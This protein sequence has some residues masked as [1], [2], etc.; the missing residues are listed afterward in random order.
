LIK[1]DWIKDIQ[2]SDHKP[3]Y[4]LFEIKFFELNNVKTE[5]IQAKYKRSSSATNISHSLDGDQK[6]KMCL[7]C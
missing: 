2:L 3:V 5:T 7:F 4:G 1:Y 6:S